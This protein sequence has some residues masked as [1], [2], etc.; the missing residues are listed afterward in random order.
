MRTLPALVVALLGVA[1][2]PGCADAGQVKTAFTFRAGPLITNA[3]WFDIAIDNEPAGRI[4]IGLYGRI[5]PRAV[6]NFVLLS[7][8]REG[9]Y[10]GTEFTRKTHK[11]IIGGDIDGNGGHS[12]FNAS[13]FYDENFRSSH[14]S[15]GIVSM[16]N[17]GRRNSNGSKF[18]ITF[19]PIEELNR[20]QVVIGKVRIGSDVLDKMEAVDTD[21][22]KR[23]LK[24]IVVADSGTM[25]GEDF[26]KME[27]DQ[28]LHEDMH[29]MKKAD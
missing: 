10:R 20:K 15:R 29:R 27:H 26:L 16:V 9:G 2:L 13:T 1:L 18:L 3:T 24:K 11:V 19:R 6:E 7:Q 4:Y 22:D 23:P 17:L 8:R 12:A 25:L 14:V 5:V 28:G 21:D